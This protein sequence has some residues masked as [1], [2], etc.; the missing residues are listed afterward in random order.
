MCIHLRQYLINHR[1]RDTTF[2]CY[3]RPICNYIR[4]LL[5]HIFCIFNIIRLSKI[6]QIFLCNTFELTCN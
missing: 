1:S 5:Y 4:H 3:D 6:Q 2:F